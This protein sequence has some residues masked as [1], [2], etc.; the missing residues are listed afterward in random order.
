[1]K[2]N[3]NKENFW[4]E[5]YK[6]YPKGVQVFCDWIDNYKKQNDWNKLFRAEVSV[7]QP[8]SFV[9]VRTDAPK[10]HDLPRAMQIGI[11]IEFICLYP[12]VHEWEIDDVY[13]YDWENSISKFFKL[14]HDHDDLR[15]DFISEIS[16]TYA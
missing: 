10:F 13:S 15:E 6:K 12:S 14:I 8:K 3:L 5:V 4:N 2:P 9:H 11:M 16:K 7:S 1:M